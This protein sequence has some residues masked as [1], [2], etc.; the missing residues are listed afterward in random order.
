VAYNKNMAFDFDTYL[1]PFTWRYGSDEMRYIWS[2]QNQH[3]IWRELWVALAQVEEEFG[4]VTREQRL[5]L[6]RYADKVNLQRTFKIE[7][8]IQH[9]LMAE[10]EAFAEQA[11]TGGGIIHLGATSADIKDNTDAIR[12]RQ[13]LDLILQELKSLLLLFADRINTWSEIPIIAFTHI[14]PAEPSTLGYRMAQYSQDLLMDW[15]TLSRLR[16]QIKGKGFKG[17]V[18]NSASFAA[19]LGIEKVALF[20]QRLSDILDLPFFEITTQVYP[21]KQDYAVLSGLADLGSS[22]HKFALDIRILQSPMIGELQE[23]FGRSQVGSSAMP[24][25]Q[26]PIKSEKVDS[27]ARVLAQ[28]PRVAWDNSANLVLERTLDDS[29]NRRITLPEAFLISDELLNVSTKIFKGLQI[30]QPAI[31]ANLAK[32]APFAAVEPILMALVKN[33]ANRQQM[34]SRIREHAMVAWTDVR[35][36]NP[37]PLLERIQGDPEIAQYLTPEKLAELMDVQGYTGVAAQRAKKFTQKILDSL[38]D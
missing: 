38:S 25:K 16:K 34:H 33:G 21:R 10:V 24:F 13:S 35:E 31:D 1:S 20:E 22:L 11:T 19:L 18:G 32:F 36:G 26:N 8:E 29:A 4:L 28:M 5:D 12:I 9:D 2:E 14:Q 7:A 17:A 3:L 23:P 27:L 30:T 37:N 6:Q 15:E